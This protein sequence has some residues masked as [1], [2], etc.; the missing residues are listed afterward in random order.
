MMRAVEVAL[1]EAIP[2]GERDNTIFL[3]RVLSTALG[4]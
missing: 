4:S 1:R 3:R 2:D